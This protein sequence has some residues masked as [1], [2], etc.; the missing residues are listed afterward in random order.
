[1]K[2]IIEFRA[3]EHDRQKM[4]YGYQYYIADAEKNNYPL[5]QL[6]GLNDKNGKPIFE[7]DILKSDFLSC[8]FAIEWNN[9]V[10]CYDWYALTET[11]KQGAS[12][13]KAIEEA[14]A[15]AKKPFTKIIEVIGNIY[16][17][18]ELLTE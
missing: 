2:R 5:M 11:E 18:P 9:E 15:K 6:T 17:N 16:E 3:W 1:M 10:A 8:N 4:V 13:A 12:L 7:G 14:P